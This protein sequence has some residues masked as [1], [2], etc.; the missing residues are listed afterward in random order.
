MEILDKISYLLKEKNKK[1]KELTD[2][3]G[4]SKYNYTD[5]KAGK[6]NSYMKYLPQIAEFL[7]V[8]LDY[9]VGTT[10]DQKDRKNE[11]VADIVLSIKNNEKIIKLVKDITF[12][13]DEQITTLQSIV[14]AFKQ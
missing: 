8:S 9:L 7:D 11:T 6:S 2:Y 1:Q 10:P 3:I 5:W 12:L 13:S 4:I 14:S